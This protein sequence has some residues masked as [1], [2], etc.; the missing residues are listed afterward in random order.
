MSCD[1]GRFDGDYLDAL[2]DCLAQGGEA[3]LQRAYELGRRAMREGLGLLELAEIHHRAL[4]DLQAQVA[5]AEEQALVLRA[6]EMF[7]AESLAPFEMAYRG[8]QE[9]AATLRLLNERLEEGARRIAHALHDEAGQLLV[10]VHLA[11]EEIAH[12]YPVARPRLAGVGSLLDKIEEELRRLSHELRPTVLDDLGLLPALDLLAQGLSS[13]NGMAIT[14]EGTRNGRL[15]A[16][17]ETALYRIVQ[18]ALTNVARHAGAKRAEVRVRKGKG[19]V[20]CL[21]RDDGAGF[22]LSEVMSRRGD[23]GLGLIGIRDRL[24]PLDGSLKITSAPGRGTR[25][26]ITI[27]L[28]A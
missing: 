10:S 16:P 8:F 3:V 4:G 26:R 20:V 13:R 19:A 18:E 11:I 17:V 9:S 25:L 27:P 24:V 15:P 5:S 2:R 7:F 6:A 14:V 22:D 23:R 12:E 1:R 21:V 28:E